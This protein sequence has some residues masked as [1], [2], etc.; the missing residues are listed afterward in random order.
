MSVGPG[1]SIDSGPTFYEV[2]PVENAP[3]PW[4]HRRMAGDRSGW[5]WTAMTGCLGFVMGPFD[6]EADARADY[7]GSSTAKNRAQYAAWVAGGRQV[8]RP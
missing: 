7:L 5:Y 1:G 6:S 8:V 3:I 2:P 4:L